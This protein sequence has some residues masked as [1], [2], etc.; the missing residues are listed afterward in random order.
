MAG[1]LQGIQE[2]LQAQAAAA[3]EILAAAAE[4][5]PGSVAAWVALGA[6]VAVPWMEL[7]G[8]SPTL[9]GADGAGAAAV[10]LFL[11][12]EPLG[13]QELVVV[14]AAAAARED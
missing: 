7:L 2:R 14:A 1:D 9:G 3:Q 8:K 5:G 4:A 10:W 12:Q 11:D 13:L 6:G